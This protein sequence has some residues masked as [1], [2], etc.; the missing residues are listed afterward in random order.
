MNMVKE[1]SK[2]SE[3]MGL[4]QEMM[5]DALEMG[6]DTGDVGA[7][8]DVIYSKICDEIGVDYQNENL[9]SNGALGISTGPMSGGMIKQS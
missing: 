1:Y 8:A 2:Q 3:K 5:E 9:V 7:D 4:K 6:L